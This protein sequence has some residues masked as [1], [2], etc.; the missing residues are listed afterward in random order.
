VKGSDDIER[1]FQA[2][3]NKRAIALLVDVSGIF[4][5]KQK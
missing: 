2:A 5:A 1:E 4:T 3:T